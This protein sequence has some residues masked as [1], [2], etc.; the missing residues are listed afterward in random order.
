MGDSLVSVIIPVFNTAPYLPEAIE[1]VLNQTYE[2]LE[3][4]IID[5]GSTDRS[6]AIC[7]QYAKADERIRVIHQENKGLSAARNVGLDVMTGEAVAFLDSDD[8]FQTSFISVSWETMNRENADLVICKY[9]THSTTGEMTISECEPTSPSIR[10]GLYDRVNALHALVENTINNHV[11]NKLYSRKL[12]NDVRFPVGHVFEDIDTSYRVFEKCERV[13]IINEPMYLKRIH[14]GSIS[15]TYS[16]DNINDWCIACD[17]LESFIK[18]NIP[19]LFSIRQLVQY[20]QKLVQS[21]IEYYVHYI[22]Q[23]GKKEEKFIRDLR[24]RIIETGGDVGTGNC[25]LRKRVLYWAICNNPGLLSTGFP[26]LHSAHQC[27]RKLF[28]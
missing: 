12:W 2:D 4:I 27:V 21:L 19:G 16:K 18:D 1:S 5:D 9:T 20:Q 22:R 24:K 8:A 28:H 23:A 11:W 13:Y 6:G 14:P 26:L 7:D 3:I 17:H 10:E 25:G 15:D